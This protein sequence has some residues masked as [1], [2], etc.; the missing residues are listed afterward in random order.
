MEPG[1]YSYLCDVH[2]GMAG[3][4]TVVD[5]ATSI[6][7]PT[8]VTIQAAGEIGATVGAA[9]QSFGDLSASMPMMSD[10]DTLRVQMG[11]PGAANVNAFFPNV[12]VIK[13]GQSITWSHPEGTFEV[14]TVAWP[15]L[16]GQDI[17]PVERDGMPPALTVGPA[18]TPETPSGTT[19]DADGK[20]NSGGIFAGQTYTLTFSE[21]G[22]YPYVCS[23]HLGMQGVVVVQPE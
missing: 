1:T 18:L 23:L 21:P 6:P 15:S 20:F 10:G 8:D 14:H 19:V 9:M 11:T 4:L 13:A 12:A 17:V 7:S 3:S 22:V 5:S 2:P 16:L